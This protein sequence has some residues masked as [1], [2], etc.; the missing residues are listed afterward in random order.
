MIAGDVGCT[1]LDIKLPM[2]FAR[3][4]PVMNFRPILRAK[5]FDTLLGIGLELN[6]VGACLEKV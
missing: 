3:L 1:I 2:N 6:W 5:I 4:A